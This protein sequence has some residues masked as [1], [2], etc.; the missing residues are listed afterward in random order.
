MMDPGKAAAYRSPRDLLF[1]LL[2][3][4]FFGAGGPPF[5]ATAANAQFLRVPHPRLPA[6]GR[7][8]CGGQAAGE[9]AGLDADRAGGPPALGTEMSRGMVPVPPMSGYGVISNDA[10]RF[11]RFYLRFF[12]P[13]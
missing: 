3:F 10:D 5:H 2:D 11:K 4:R 9:G 13:P 6:A 8:S 7:P 12:C 1:L